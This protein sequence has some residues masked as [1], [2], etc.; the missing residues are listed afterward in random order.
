M[1]KNLI[2]EVK[3]ISRLS[4]K[5]GFGI[6]LSWEGDPKNQNTQSQN[7]AQSVEPPVSINLISY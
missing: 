3:Q 6:R 1:H 5:N 2:K 4:G 7:L